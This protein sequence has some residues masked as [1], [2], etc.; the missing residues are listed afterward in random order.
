MEMVKEGK[1]RL[2]EEDRVTSRICKFGESYVGNL[3]C[4]SNRLAM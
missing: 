4:G 1:R 2:F 3:S